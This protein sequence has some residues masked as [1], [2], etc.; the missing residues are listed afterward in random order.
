MSHTKS[1]KEASN[2]TISIF[3][4]SHVNLHTEYGL[5]GTVSRKGDVYGYGIMLMETFTRKKPTD[6]TFVGEMGLKQWVANSFPHVI[7]QVVDSNL[8]KLIK[9][10]HRA[11]EMYCLCSVTELGLAC[12]AMSP[13]ERI[14]MNNVVARLNKIKTKFVNEIGRV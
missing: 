4:F 12:C 9:G 3:F 14:A 2:L 10:E 1:T 6:E 5:E 8:V 13:E 11:A 7:T